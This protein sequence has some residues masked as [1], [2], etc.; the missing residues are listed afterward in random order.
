MKYNFVFQ[1]YQRIN[2][3]MTNDKAVFTPILSAAGPGD[4]AVCIVGMVRS[5]TSLTAQ[6]L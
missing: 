2:M 6:M 5:G 1:V 4:H 3:L